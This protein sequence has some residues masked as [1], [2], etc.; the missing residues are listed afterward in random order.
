MPD[1]G[2]GRAVAVDPVL[3]VA[4]LGEVPAVHRRRGRA[5]RRGDPR[6]AHL[7]AGQPGSGGTGPKAIY[8]EQGMGFHYSEQKGWAYFDGPS[9]TGQS[10]HAWNKGGTDGYAYRTD[11]DFKTHIQ[12]NKAYKAAGDVNSSS[13]LTKTLADNVHQKYL[14][15]LDPRF[16]DAPRINEYARRC[17]RPRTRC[18]TTNRCRRRFT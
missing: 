1:L 16:D 3:S 14:E 12:D 13:A 8:G 17:G 5:D 11:G 4:L 9:G 7:A 10:G 18:A 15:S 6:G 2:A